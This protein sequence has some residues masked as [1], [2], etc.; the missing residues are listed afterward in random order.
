MEEYEVGASQKACD[1]YRSSI[2]NPLIR[3]HTDKGIF[4]IKKKIPASAGR[5]AGKT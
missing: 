4:S 5:F 2:K 1:I 3:W